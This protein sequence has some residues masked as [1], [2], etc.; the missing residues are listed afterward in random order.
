MG[1]HHESQQPSENIKCHD[2]VLPTG[3]FER[4]DRI[5]LLKSLHVTGPYLIVHAPGCGELVVHR[6][7]EIGELPGPSKD[8]SYA[9]LHKDAYF[10]KGKVYEDRAGLNGK[11]IRIYRLTK[12]QETQIL[13][14]IKKESGAKNLKYSFASDNCLTFVDGV[15][16]VAKRIG[17]R[18]VYGR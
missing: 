13:Q 10:D 6:S 4:I 3:G 5:E 8:F 14:Y 2:R 12:T 18:L 15:E 1:K 11:P 7:I 9:P 17:A 16:K